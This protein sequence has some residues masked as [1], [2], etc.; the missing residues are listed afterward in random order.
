M[1]DQTYKSTF[2]PQ[3]YD[4]KHGPEWYEKDV[5]KPAPGSWSDN[6]YHCK[7]PDNGENKGSDKNTHS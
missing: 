4:G 3:N 1:A 7:E 2:G 6:S 5:K